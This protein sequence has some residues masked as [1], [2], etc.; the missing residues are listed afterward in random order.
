MQG[1]LW[2]FNFKWF[3]KLKCTNEAIGNMVQGAQESSQKAETI[4]ESMN[5]TTKAVEQVALTAQEQAETAEKL[6]ELVLKFSV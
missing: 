2:F 1:R 3:L 6:N 4:K 5:E